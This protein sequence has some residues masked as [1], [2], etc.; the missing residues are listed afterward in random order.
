MTSYKVFEHQDKNHKVVKLGFAWLAIPFNLF[1]FLSRRLW[2]VFFSYMFIIL[3]LSGIDYEIYGELGYIDSST[4]SDFHWL[5]LLVE[6]LI[7]IIPGF[8]G[9]QWTENNLKRRGYKFSYT[10][11]AK[12]LRHAR[13][14]ALNE[15]NTL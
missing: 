7:F 3:I 5:F 14:I 9:N 8:K 10:V 1:W 15:R 2:G 11:K 4:A 6:I 12:S 13:E